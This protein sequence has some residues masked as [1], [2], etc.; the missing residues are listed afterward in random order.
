[1]TEYHL[2]HIAHTPCFNLTN[3]S[4]YR[5]NKPQC[6]TAPYKPKISPVRDCIMHEAIVAYIHLQLEP[7]LRFPT[8]QY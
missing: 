2:P 6:R 8:I 1:M 5:E 4:Y 3:N 7:Y